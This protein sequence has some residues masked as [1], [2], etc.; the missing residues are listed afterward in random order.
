MI[1][2]HI[3][4][5][6]INVLKESPRYIINR[7][8]NNQEIIS[9]LK[10][11]G[12]IKKGE[13]INT[14]HLY[15]QPDGVAT[16]FSRTFIQQDNR[17][18]ALNFCQETVARSFE[19]L[20][21]YERSDKKSDKVLFQHLL[22]DLQLATSG[23]TNLKFT[24]ISDTKFCCDIDTI[25]ESINARL[26]SY[27]SPITDD[28]K[29]NHIGTNNKDSKHN[30]SKQQ[31]RSHKPNNSSRPSGQSEQNQSIDQTDQTDQS[32]QEYDSDS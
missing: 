28:L 21:T 1:Y 12:K 10:F 6:A 5:A 32:E 17:G 13:K 11:I 26:G 20:V 18:N 3:A 14:R 29:N 4:T 23:L 25:L 9:R 8:D 27:I 2:S 30:E 31:S 19:L 16:T 24:Y 15:V 22:K 7:M